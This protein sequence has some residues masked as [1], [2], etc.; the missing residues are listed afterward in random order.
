MK[1][2]NNNFNLIRL[3]AALQVAIVHSAAYLNIDI[4][5]L[6]FLDL[7][8]GVP[9]FFFISGFLIIKSFKKNKNN[10]LKNFFYNR[11]LRIYPGLYFCFI[12][13]F[14]SV[15]F[16]KYLNNVD[17]NYYQL[18]LWLVTQLSFFQFYNP[19][20]FRNYGVGVVN[21]SLWTISIEIQFYLLT[22]F[23]YLLL[24]KYK[25]LLIVVFITFIFLNI[26]NSVLNEKITFF[27]KLFN[28]SFLPWLYM[29]LW[30][31]YLESNQ[32]LKKKIKNYNILIIIF[33]LII[34]N[35]SSYQ[36][37]I[38]RGKTNALNPVEFFFL[39]IIIFKIAYMKIKIPKNFFNK[40]DISYGVYLYHMPIVN[41]FIYKN[42]KETY[43][44]FMLCIILTLL[45][46]LI[47]WK[48]IEKPF[49]SLKKNSLNK[50]KI[51]ALS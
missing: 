36:L 31:C 25:K 46:A 45:F 43:L 2:T 39:S 34:L 40:N 15:L 26:V 21:G 5:Y 51:N 48:I 7:F 35:Y 23:L 1:S 28:V 38:F 17:I 50:I 19:D 47:S 41:F 33:I 29:F 6:K 12:V 11:I 8:P 13:T 20:F 49:L 37:N 10:K 22:F 9:I 30:G 4:T 27:S 44:A 14:L 16:S 24:N 18:F 42:L 3:F 32:K